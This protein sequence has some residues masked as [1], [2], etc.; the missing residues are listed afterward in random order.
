MMRWV[1]L[2]PHLDDAVLSAGG[3]I[4]EQTRAGKAVEIW[5]LMSG[6]PANPELSEFALQMHQKWGTTTAE[7][8][9]AT[10]RA[11]D[12]R[13]AAMLGAV[14]V[15]FEFLDAIYRRGTSG[16]PLY[17][18]PIDAQVPPQEAALPKHL[19]EAIN[20]RLNP[21]D[22]VICQLAI[23]QH[24]DHLLARNAA[25][26]LGRPLLYTADLPY[27][28]WSPKDLA[29]KTAGMRSTL[30]PFSDAAAEAWLAAVGEYRSQLST[31][32]ESWELL[33]RD[34]RAHWASQGGIR[35]WARS[36]PQGEGLD[37]GP[38]A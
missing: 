10:R 24:V 2:S 25:E 23:G 19:S 16:E 15:H 30:Y 9:V 33:C 14:P 31:L 11:E 7:A 32:Y 38:K 5:T 4:Y 27:L 34:M 13:A 35:L 29:E 37:S 1:Y 28:L 20:R 17:A 22:R 3:L 6:I 26:M 21:D 36:E 12:Q 8:T 18:E